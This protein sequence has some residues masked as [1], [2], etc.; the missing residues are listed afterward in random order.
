[1]IFQLSVQS[2]DGGEWIDIPEVVVVDKI[3][4][5]PNV[6]PKRCAVK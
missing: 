2:L 4:V 6:M 5:N 3:P 1:M